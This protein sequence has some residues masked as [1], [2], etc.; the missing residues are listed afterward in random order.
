MKRWALMTLVLYL[1]ALSVIV[2]PLFL[3]ISETGADILPGFYIWFVPL[4]VLVEA[5]LL[6]VPVAVVRERPI[7]RRKIGFSAAVAA[8]PMAALALGFFG[9]IALMVFGEIS[10]EQYLYDWPAL[11]VPAVA[12]LVW[13]VL[14]YRTFS[15]EEPQ[16]FVANLTRWLF[17]GSV[18]ELL[19]AVPSHIISRHREECCA[20]PL[21]LIGIATGLAIAL[22]SFGPGLFFVFARRTRD[23]NRK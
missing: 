3:A 13:G 19:V 15:N 7:K 11:I 21:T 23:K 12:W 5:V 14:F 20:P 2:I 17:R 4:L 8:A 22:M 1:L 10:A 18:L 16:S 6:L 9:S